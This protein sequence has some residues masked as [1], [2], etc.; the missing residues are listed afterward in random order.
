MTPPPTSL[1]RGSKRSVGD[2][3]TNDIEEDADNSG[4]NSDG[5]EMNQGDAWLTSMNDSSYK[6]NAP[7]TDVYLHLHKHSLL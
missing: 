4:L 5:E 2:N 7:T 3:Y 1:P 6:P